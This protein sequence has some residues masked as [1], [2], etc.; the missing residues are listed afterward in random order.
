MSCNRTRKKD[1][2][3]QKQKT[4]NEEVENKKSTNRPLA[5][6]KFQ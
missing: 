1:A 6:I 5:T 3:H 2:H 4:M